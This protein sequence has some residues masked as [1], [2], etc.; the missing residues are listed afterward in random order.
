MKFTPEKYRL[1]DAPMQPFIDEEEIW[2]LLNNT[3]STPEK[4]KDIVD[5]SL[6]KNRLN[7]KETATLINAADE[8]SV[9]IIKD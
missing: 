9:N 5:K 4:V 2:D 7:L 8:E 1:P 6:A 3:V